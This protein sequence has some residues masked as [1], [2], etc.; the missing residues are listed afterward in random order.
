MNLDTLLRKV[1]F[2]FFPRPD[3]FAEYVKNG[4]TV[5]KNFSMQGGVLLD[6][7]HIWHISIGDDVTLAPG[8]HILAHDA[9]TK[10]HLGYVRIGKVTIGDKVFIGACSIVLPGVTIGSNVV[11]GAGSVVSR[12]IPDNSVAMGNPARVICGIEDFLDKK[13]RE[14]SEVPCFD[15]AHTVRGRVTDAMKQDMNL[16]MERGIGYIE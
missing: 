13:R 16:R 15:E 10:K 5:G 12:D 9:S 11:I 2:F 8:V 1:Y 6:G 7:S 3:V 14:M 4:L